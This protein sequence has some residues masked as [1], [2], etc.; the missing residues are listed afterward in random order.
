MVV[1][2][3]TGFTAGGRVEY[4]HLIL[5]YAVNK[6]FASSRR[7]NRKLRVVAIVFKHL[8]V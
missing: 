1:E 2:S 3:Q 8:I 7:E 5:Q 6:T 4:N